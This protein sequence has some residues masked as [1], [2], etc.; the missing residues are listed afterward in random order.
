V[1]VSDE[2]Y[3]FKNEIDIYGETIGI[4]SHAKGNEHGII[5]RSKSVAESMSAVFEA[6]WSLSVA[7]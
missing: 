7:E 5:I 4:T 1:S 6:L 2:R 3:Q